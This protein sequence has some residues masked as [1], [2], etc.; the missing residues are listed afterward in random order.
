MDSMTQSHF[1]VAVVG[2]GPA[3]IAA[4]VTAAEYG[5]HVALID[6]N[7]HAGGQIW[8][9]EFRDTAH[10]TNHGTASRWYKRLSRS[11]ATVIAGARVFHIADRTLAAETADGVRR[12]SCTELI[13]ATGARELFLPFPSWTLPNVLG[14]GGLQG[15]MKSGLPVEGKRIVV[16]GTGPLLLAVAAYARKRGAKVLGICE[17]TSTRKLMRF[18]MAAAAVPSKIADAARFVWSL[19][20]IPHWTNSW[21]AAASGNGRVERVRVVRGGETRE[22]EC[23]YLACGFHLVPN[24]ELAKMAGCKIENGFVAVDAMQRTSATRVY[25]AGEPTSIGGVEM[26]V[27]EGRIAGYAAAGNEG[28]ARQL[29]RERAVYAKFAE[30]LK[31]AFALRPELKSLAALDTLLCRCEDVPFGQAR[32]FDSWRAAKLHTRCGM[33]PCQG[34]VCGAAAEFLF[35]WSA[36]SVRPPAVP[37]ECASLAGIAARATRSAGSEAGLGRQG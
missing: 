18:T 1:D 30:E 20:G 35:G 27:L 36:D 16:A 24:V 14:A 23:D 15:L 13:L 9:G 31:S 32:A 2:A 34:R 19:R 6:D 17:Q 4:A 26:A 5:A 22:I 11:G 28:A 37:V 8:R 21:V 25:C 29:F 3:G 7:P 10:G 33:G 12:I